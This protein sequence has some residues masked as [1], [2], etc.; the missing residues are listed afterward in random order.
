MGEV[1]GRRDSI[2]VE[3]LPFTVLS[4]ALTAAIV[5][6]GGSVAI[7]LEAA[8]AV[9]ADGAEAASWVA[10]LCL[11]IAGTSFYLSWRYRMPF[12]TAWST[13]GAAVIATSAAGVGL[14]AAIGAFLFAAV[15]VVATMAFRP[16]GRLLARLPTTIAAAM[17]AGILIRFCLEVADAAEQAPLFVVALVIAFFAISQKAAGMAVP[18]V[19]VLGIAVA[20]LSGE[21][22]SDCCDLALTGLLPSLPDFQLPV[23]IGLGLP[24]YLVTMASQNLTGLAVLKAD[25]YEAP[26]AGSIAPTGLASLVL[27]PFGAHGVCLSSITAAICS[28]PSCHPDPARRWLV[29]PVYGLCYLFFAAFTESFVALLLALPAALITTFTGIA[30][31]GPLRGA[32]G[33][34]LSGE[35]REAALLTFVVAASGV[36]FAGIGSAVWALLAGLLLYAAKGLKRPQG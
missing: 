6:F 31:F 33:T 9:G 27:A 20:A 12:I 32:L 10:A 19:L 23:L 5:G 14:E 18:I 28:G 16:L 15:L 25:G 34:A 3:S 2:A 26:A 13:P 36:G 11:G 35:D 21:M 24:L 4:S 29:G 17:L 7:V 30:L 8:R 22:A 1:E